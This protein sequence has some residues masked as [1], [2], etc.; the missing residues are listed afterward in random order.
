MLLDRRADINARGKYG[1]ALMAASDSGH[2][3]VVRI[4]LARG[5]DVS[6]LGGEYGNALQVVLQD[7]HEKIMQ[8]L[9]E[10]GAAVSF[11]RRFQNTLTA[12]FHSR[13][14]R[15]SQMIRSAPQ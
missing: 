5:A 13:T 4:L 9:L 11:Q 8:T 6:N 12:S 3:K 15:A 1:N 2:E 10:I 14:E 7:G